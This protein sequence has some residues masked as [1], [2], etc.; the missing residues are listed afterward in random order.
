MVRAVRDKEI[1]TDVF[2]KEQGFI[3]QHDISGSNIDVNIIDL[4]AIEQSISIRP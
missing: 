3:Y 1:S 2:T 4:A